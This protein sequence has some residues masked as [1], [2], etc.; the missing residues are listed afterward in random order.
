[1]Q[2]PPETAR[3]Q[4]QLSGCRQRL[5]W[6]WRPGVAGISYLVLKFNAINKWRQDYGN[7]VL[8]PPGRPCRD[9]CHRGRM[10]RG[11]RVIIAC[12]RV[13]LAWGPGVAAG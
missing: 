1:M 9:R 4:P 13:I 8:Q 3:C 12:G 6:T 2:A 11:V 10:S 5:R 7:D